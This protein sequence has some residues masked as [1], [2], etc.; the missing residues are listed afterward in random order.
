MHL[1][2]WVSIRP[3]I[4]WFLWHPLC[5][6][7]WLSLYVR[8]HSHYTP[9]PF[10]L[11]LHPIP[12]CLPRRIDWMFVLRSSFDDFKVQ[13][14]NCIPAVHFWFAC[15]VSVARAAPG[16]RAGVADGCVR[17]GTDRRKR[18]TDMLATQVVLAGVGVA[19]VCVRHWACR[20]RRNTCVA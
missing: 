18:I 5:Y 16:V 10:S 6:R 7:W 1:Q 8:K 15:V 19:D 4:R 2:P 12:H 3:F 20:R 14:N 17:H 13:T 11:F 9:C